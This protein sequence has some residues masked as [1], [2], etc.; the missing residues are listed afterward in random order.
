M[1]PPSPP[2]NALA[3]GRAPK[4]PGRRIFETM[5][6]QAGALAFPACPL[7]TPSPLTCVARL[8]PP[9]RGGSMPLPRLPPRSSLDALGAHGEHRPLPARLLQQ[10][11]RL[12]DTRIHRPR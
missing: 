4:W 3:H 9:P 5:L 2:C 6:R 7:S 11:Q 8:L 10:L 1:P 12:A